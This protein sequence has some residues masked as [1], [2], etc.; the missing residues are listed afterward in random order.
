MGAAPHGAT[1]VSAGSALSPEQST[2]VTADG[3]RLFVLDWLLP[4]DQA[5]RGGIVLM[6]GLGEHCGRYAHV[7]EFFNQHGWSVRAYDHRGHGRSGGP[8]GDVP[9]DATLSADAEM[10]IA[11]FVRAQVGR[12]AG[13]PMLFGHS[14]GGLFAARFACSH[15]LPL[16]GLILSSPLLALK[17]TP[18]QAVLSHIM[19]RVAPG[20][21]VSNG[22]KA[23]YL[24]HDLALVEAYRVDPYGQGK[25]SARLLQALFA[26]IAQV[27]SE[28]ATLQLPVL[29]VV[30]GDD[31]LVDASGSDVLYARLDPTR[32]ILH[33]YAQLYHEIFNEID[34]ARV[35]DDVRAW[36][37][38]PGR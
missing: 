38:M 22:L 21:A 25:I 19:R 11:D 14:M 32:A 7:A 20:F 30:A 4:P 18:F 1:A 17:L 35:F 34:K 24:S 10:V 13:P 31:R 8:R 3:T 33:R 36:L 28:A 12:W 6:H 23:E 9:A 27:H 29:M 2:L 26:A 16:R 5:V 15:R 37:A